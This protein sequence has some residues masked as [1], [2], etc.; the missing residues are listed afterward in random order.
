MTAETKRNILNAGNEHGFVCTAP[1]RDTAGIG[2]PERESPAACGAAGLDGE[3]VRAED[4][5]SSS[6]S[7][8]LRMPFSL[9]NTESALS[10]SSRALRWCSSASV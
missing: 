1:I 7:S 9:A 3:V 5:Q 4:R 6:W 2:W 8:V 10:R